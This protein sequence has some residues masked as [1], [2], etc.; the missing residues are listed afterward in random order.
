MKLKSKSNITLSWVFIAGLVTLSGF[1]ALSAKYAQALDNSM[2]FTESLYLER[3]FLVEN[4]YI[5]GGK[6][7]LENKTSYSNFTGQGI[8]NGT[9]NITV[10]GNASETLRNN[11]TSYLQGKTKFSTDGSNTVLYDFYAIGKYNSN[12]TF[13][14]TGVA[15][16]EDK[17]V[18]EFSFLSNSIAIYK[19]QVNNNG[20]GTFLMW[21]VG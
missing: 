14:S 4:Y 8:L 12:G 9:I 18:G 16:F 20:T 19:D 5:E 11:D 3:P 6:P 1:V 2:N 10:E 13:N 21:K 15:I 17:A 7:G